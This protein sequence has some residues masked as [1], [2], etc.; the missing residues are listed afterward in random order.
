[1]VSN[2]RPELSDRYAVLVHDGCIW[3][4][5]P[6]RRQAEMMVERLAREGQDVSLAVID[7]TTG[8]AE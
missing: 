7:Y 5:F 3:Y 1:M 2:T 4:G 8:G 6:D